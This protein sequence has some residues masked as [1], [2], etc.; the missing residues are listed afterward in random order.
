MTIHQPT[1]PPVF[2][3]DNPPNT[4][5]NAAYNYSVNVG[6][7]PLPALSVAD[8]AL[9]PGLSIDNTNG[10]WIRGSATATGVYH[11]T[12]SADNGH[13]TPATQAMTMTVYQKPWITN[14]P[15][16]GVLNT[17]YSSQLT[18]T[19]YPTPTYSAPS[20]SLPPGLT[21]SSTGLLSGT[22][23]AAGHYNVNITLANDFGTVTLPFRI[24]IRSQATIAGTPTAA[25]VGRR[26]T[27][28]TPSAATRSPRPR[29]CPGPCPMG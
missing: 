26:T 14:G 27:T 5:L 9:P 1:S 28:A 8:G 13:G 11:F 18:G 3:G 24:D 20:G 29:C 10:H 7:T 6:G 19:G 4:E 16:W 21:L 15:G 22:P 25:V 23:T 2:Y 17:P 12:L